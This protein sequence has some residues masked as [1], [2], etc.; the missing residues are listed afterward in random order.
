MFLVE[1]I[2]AP[3]C[4]N[5]PRARA[6]LLKGFAEA[7]IPPKWTE[8][9]RGD[10]AGPA[11]VL[12]Y[13]SP[14]ILVNGKD[15]A[16]AEPM[17]GVS[18]CRL[19]PGARGRLEGAPPVRLIAE[20]LRSARGSR[21]AG[22]GGKN[23]SGWRSSL[24]VLPG[25]G[26]SLLPV[27]LCPA[28][29][30]AYA[31]ILG[32]LGLGAFPGKAFMLPLTFLCLAITLA[33]FCFRA[34]RNGRYGPLAAGA[35]ASGLLLAGKFALDSNAMVY[36]GITLLIGAALWNA[37]PAGKMEGSCSACAAVEPVSQG[38]SCCETKTEEMKT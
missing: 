32:S 8:W 2:H 25:L 27:G 20:A 35:L 9:S 21:E 7:G 24:T 1:L 36:S 31:G 18:T 38:A 22:E 6:H 23:G 5:V 16:G 26:A 15:V 19:Y 30:P 17:A 28:C 10:A 14:T 3:D 29:W 11:H 33:A 34:R 37:W 13:G 4:P 12:H